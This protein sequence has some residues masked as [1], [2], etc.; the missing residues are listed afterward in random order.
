MTY[1]YE[2]RA[3][4]GTDLDGD[5]VLTGVDVDGLEAAQAL[6]L[7]ADGVDVARELVEVVLQLLRAARVDDALALRHHARAQLRVACACAHS[8]QQP[9]NSASVSQ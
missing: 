5:E 6:A 1:T 2:K 3:S 4:T 9:S 8:Q 7:A